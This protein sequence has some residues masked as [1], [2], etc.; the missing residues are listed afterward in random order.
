MLHNAHTHTPLTLNF[1]PLSFH[2]ISISRTPCQNFQRPTH[3]WKQQLHRL[4][5]SLS[6]TCERNFPAFPQTTLHSEREWCP[7]TGGR[8]CCVRVFYSQLDKISSVCLCRSVVQDQIP[9]P[10]GRQ[11]ARKICSGKFNAV[12]PKAVAR[13]FFMFRC[14]KIGRVRD[15]N[16]WKKNRE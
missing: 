2:F 14:T 5:V 3:K 11:C 7:G 10:G 1:I 13:F 15:N 8:V 4:V 9:N 16:L 12:M 6:A